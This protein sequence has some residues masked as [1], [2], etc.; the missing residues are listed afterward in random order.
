MPDLLKNVTIERRL[1]DLQ[2]VQEYLEA[3][4]VNIQ[5]D[6]QSIK[7]VVEAIRHDIEWTIKEHDAK[8]NPHKRTSR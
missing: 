4:R 1:K 8:D 5:E 3:L 6:I 7:D 2:S